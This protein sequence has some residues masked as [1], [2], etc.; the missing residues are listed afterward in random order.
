MIGCTVIKAPT[1]GNPLLMWRGKTHTTPI[2]KDP[3]QIIQTNTVFKDYSHE[4]NAVKCVCVSD[5][6]L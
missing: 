3:N 4:L 1:Q 5:S 6:I 2:K